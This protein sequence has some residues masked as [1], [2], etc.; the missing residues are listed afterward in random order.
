MKNT[1]RSLLLVALLV[2]CRSQ[3]YVPDD[4]PFIRPI[5]Q[6]TPTTEEKGV[7][8]TVSSVRQALMQP[9]TWPSGS[10]GDLYVP[11]GTTMAGLLGRPYDFRN[12]EIHGTLQL[13]DGD[14]WLL[15]GVSGDFVLTGTIVGRDGRAPVLAN[16]TTPSA[17]ISE[18]AP[19]GTQ[20]EYTTGCGRG[21]SGGTAAKGTGRDAGGGDKCY[22]NGGGG[23]ADGQGGEDGRPHRGGNGASA[24][25]GGGGSATGR[26]GLGGTEF[27]ADGAPGEAAY[28]HARYNGA[29]G[30]GG[31]G[32]RR[33]KAG[34]G[35]F[36]KVLGQFDSLQGTIDVSGQAGGAG[37]DGGLAK[38]GRFPMGGAGGGGGGGGFGG[39][40]VIHCNDA[41]KLGLVNRECGEGGT[42]GTRGISD[43]KGQPHI[44]G[45]PGQEGAPGQRGELVVVDDI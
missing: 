34:Q 19:D 14:G 16:P 32:G 44:D 41:S 10:Q 39:K 23:G 8:G 17:V 6:I 45:T 3:M 5:E 2:G 43:R 35:V 22:G 12:V 13:E 9:P 33:G 24:V 37:G 1:R 18:S 42:G 11:A 29:Y 15:L 31:G 30:G 4:R 28:S 38:G 25:W 20:L 21:G 26:G 27:G 36:I 40:V 7:P